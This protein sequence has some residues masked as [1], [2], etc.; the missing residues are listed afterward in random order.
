M[1]PRRTYIKAAKAPLLSVQ[2]QNDIRV[3]QE[4]AQQVTDAIKAEGGVAEVV[5]YPAEG[6]GFAKREDQ[7]DS[8]QRTIDWFDRYLRRTAR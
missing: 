6:H 2:G 8:L 4:Q 7:I 5:F 3:P 1:R